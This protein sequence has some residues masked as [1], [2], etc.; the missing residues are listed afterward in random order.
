M[1]FCNN[2]IIVLAHKLR[3]KVRNTNSVQA[4]RAI[5]CT[6]VARLSKRSTLASR[7]PVSVSGSSVYGNDH[8]EGDVRHSVSAGLW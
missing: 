3:F 4:A 1:N 6:T 8:T 2:E 7:L 5:S